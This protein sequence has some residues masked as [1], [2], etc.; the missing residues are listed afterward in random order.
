MATTRSTVLC[1]AMV[2]VA[3]ALTASL[4][5]GDETHSIYGTVTGQDGAPVPAVTLSFAEA[6]PSQ[7]TD[8]D[9]RYQVSGAEPG[10]SYTI[11]PASPGMSF[12][13]ASRTVTVTSGDEY[14]NFRATC[15][16]GAEL[17]SIG[18]PPDQ[19]K[20]P[21]PPDVTV[22][23]GGETWK[24]GGSYKIE[25]T[26]GYRPTV[27]LKSIWPTGPSL[28]ITTN[29][30]NDGSFWWKVPASLPPRNDYR[31]RI[32]DTYGDTTSPEFTIKE[33][34]LV[35][36]PTAGGVSWRRGQPY[37][38]QWQ[39]FG[40]SHVKIQLYRSWNL[41]RL[42][43][44]STPNDGSFWWKVPDTQAL[45]T[46]FRIKVTGQSKSVVYDFSDKNFTIAGV[47]KVTWP[48]APGIN[49]PQGQPQLIKWQGYVGTNVRIELLKNWS[50]AKVITTGTP[51]DGQFCWQMPWGMTPG[52][53]YR[54]RV[55]S[56]NDSTQKD[57]SNNNFTVSRVPHVK[58][59]TATGIVW[60]RGMVYTIKWSGYTVDKILIQLYRDGVGQV[61]Q[62]ADGT[63]NDG[64]F[65]WQVPSN[66]PT[67]GGYR[68]LVG[69]SYKGDADEDMSDNP[70]SI[71]Q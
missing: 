1:C 51:N 54:I 11:V 23:A 43:S 63:P 26:G 44:W 37:K 28:T 3:L 15:S 6:L 21:P 69:T 25:W 22:P 71:S 41:N 20:V 8:H 31:I 46:T 61:A 2:L 18:S 48:T 14:A 13:P 58:Y 55:I 36:Y 45:G 40:G 7:T 5:C 19:A 39:G 68:I 4:A 67:G 57:H 50:V 17:A 53:D 12:S 30:T 27:G 49:W 38:I 33:M 32:W 35:T 34:P 42:I 70:F 60:G 29:T 64:Q 24:Q 16:G 62:I 47:Q 52:A 9:G 56:A 65:V 59:P 10:S 66:M